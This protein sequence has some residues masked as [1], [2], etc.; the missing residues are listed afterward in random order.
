VP[1]V[2]FE[3]TSFIGALGLEGVTATMMFKGTPN[4]DFFKGGF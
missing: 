3:R 2:R 1:D 4:G